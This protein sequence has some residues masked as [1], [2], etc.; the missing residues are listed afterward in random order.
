MTHGN[1][2]MCILGTHGVHQGLGDSQEGQPGV[3]TSWW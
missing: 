2:G 1:K 3:H